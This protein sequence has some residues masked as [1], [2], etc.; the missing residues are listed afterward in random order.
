MWKEDIVAGM[1][2]EG[3]RNTTKIL[4]GIAG[5]KADRYSY[6]ILLGSVFLFQV[7]RPIP[8]PC[9]ITYYVRYGNAPASSPGGDVHHDV[10]IRE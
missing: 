2:L 4:F 10:I 9:K 6:T 3:L 1:C 8:H 7:N 5:V